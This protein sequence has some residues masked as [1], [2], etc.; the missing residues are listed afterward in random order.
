MKR[1]HV[2]GGVLAAALLAAGG[3]GIDAALSSPASTSAAPAATPSAT[4]SAPRPAA[5]VTIS[6]SPLAPGTALVD[7]AGRALYLF[8]A[9]R[10]TTS[11]CTG[12]C[13]QIWPPVLAQN[14]MPTA[15]GAIQAQL[16]GTASRDDGTT[17]VTYN[18]H[19]LYYF[20]L[21]KTPGDTKGQG[22]NRFGAPW[23]VLTPAGDKI[24]SDEA[25]AAPPAPTTTSSSG[26]GTGYGY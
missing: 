15:A 23:Y 10:G 19:P 24:D 12:A 18:G 21:D 9:D 2:F 3:Y 17:Q 13:A 6:A 7:N 26:L 22:L 25:A 4:S 5:P 11:A 8:E 16:L 14:G 1:S 20:T